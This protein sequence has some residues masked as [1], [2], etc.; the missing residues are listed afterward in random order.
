MTCSPRRPQ[1]ASSIRAVWLRGG[2]Q[3]DA[4]EPDQ[5]DDRAYAFAESVHSLKVGTMSVTEVDGGDGNFAGSKL[6]P[7]KQVVEKLKLRLART[8]AR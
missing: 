1:L 7:V 3:A 6:K 8:A 2:V 5:D 4:G